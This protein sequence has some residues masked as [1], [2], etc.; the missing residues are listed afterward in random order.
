MIDFSGQVALVTGAGRG[1]GFSYARLLAE[2]GATVIVQ[3]VGAASDGRGNDP[4]VAEAAA[5]RIVSEG[6]SAIPSADPIGTREEC[7]ALVDGIVGRHGRLDVLIHNAG[8]VG[9]EGIEALTP[10]FLDRMV[11]L[12]VHAPL[13]LAQAAWPVMR[14]QTYGRILVTTS[15]R[16]LY[17]EH[18]QTGLSAYAAAKIAAVGI[19]NTL[20]ME[21]EAHG[22]RVNAISPVAKTRMWGVD[23]EPDELRPDDVA[24][25]ALYLVSAESDA[26]G[27]VLRAANGQ[28]VA[29]KAREAEDVDYPRGLAAVTAATPEAVAAAW[30]RIAISYPERR[31]AAPGAVSAALGSVAVLGES[32]LWSE[33]RKRLLWVDTEGRTL[34]RFDPAT[35]RNVALGMPDVVGMVAERA[36]G[37]LVVA[38]GCDLATVDDAGMVRRIATA[39][40]ARE[41]WRLNDG[42]FDG[43]G[44]LW[45]GMIDGALSEG[46]GFLYR[47]DPDGSWH[48]MADGFTLANGLDWSPDRRTLYVTDSRAPAIYAYDYNEAAGTLG[49]RRAFVT[50]RPEDGFPDGLLVTASGSMWSTMFAG[51]AIQQ[52]GADGRFGQRVALPVSR[53]TSCAPMPDGTGLFVTT[54]RLG[55]ATDAL[56]REPLAGALLRMNLTGP[57]KKSFSADRHQR[58]RLS[59]IHH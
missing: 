41:G 31:A 21:G 27:W 1:L 38:L 11:G 49:E 45:I 13:W 35:G 19:A 20:A 8:W 12:G 30:P 55:L 17:P 28:F 4:R 7:A 46:S 5:A 25:G 29:T 32:P 52:I 18:A 6:G 16:A 36:D 39:P 22:I 42:R 40:H 23:G 54:A 2:R 10:E 48:V 56:D 59:Q 47:Y 33:R 50:F 44:R 14:R 26:T 24:T 9:Y 34:N 37:A 43:R 58:F 15:D 3:D 53:P 51:S 57:T